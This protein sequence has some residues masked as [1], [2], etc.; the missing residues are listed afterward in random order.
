MST[1]ELQISNPPR[2]HIP[3][4]VQLL[5]VDLAATN[6]R[7]RSLLGA[8]A[9]THRALRS[10]CQR[11]IFSSISSRSHNAFL[12]FLEVSPHLPTYVRTLEIRSL[13]QLNE[14]G[15][16]ETFLDKLP[17][18]RTLS[19]GN[20]S[21]THWGQLVTLSWKR[22]HKRLAVGL[23]RHIRSPQLHSL[24]ICGISGF[25]VEAFIHLYRFSDLQILAVSKLSLS[26]N[27]DYQQE[28]ISTGSRNS[29]LT[30]SSA[31][32]L[33]Q[34]TAGEAST[35]LLK[36]LLGIP[37]LFCE[38]PPAFNFC[39]VRKLSVVWG[40]SETTKDMIAASGAVEE[41]ACLCTCG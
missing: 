24:T 19:I 26:K 23:L 39:N 16:G 7:L 3:Y 36:V 20:Y 27:G 10:E 4:D 37:T 25:P 34:I 1:Q 5:I 30:A 22:L 29:N 32:R 40:C 13:S 28:I 18:L 17:H 9:S 11:H 35:D 31:Q 12:E 41:L 8:L 2:L 6:Y 14:E 33:C 15:E 21:N 38:I